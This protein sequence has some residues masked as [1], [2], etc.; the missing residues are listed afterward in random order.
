MAVVK[1]GK[2]S[3]QT[4]T[5]SLLSQAIQNPVS[6]MSVVPQIDIRQYFFKNDIKPLQNAVMCDTIQHRKRR[7]LQE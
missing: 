2:P 1:N 4:Q 5:D 6:L 7:F 3:L